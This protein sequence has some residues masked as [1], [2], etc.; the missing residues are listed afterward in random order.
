MSVVKDENG[1]KTWGFHGYYR[2]A[3]GVRRQYHRR[4]YSTKKEAKE[5][6]QRLLK[7]S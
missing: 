4:G 2:D 5:A 1:R 6:E 3:A 7:K